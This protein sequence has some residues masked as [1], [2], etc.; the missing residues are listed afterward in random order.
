MT[1]LD[2]QID[3]IAYDGNGQ[4]VLLAE[5]R[6]RMGKSPEWAARFR[7]NLLEHG[8][9][10]NARFFLIATPERMYFWNRITKALAMNCR[11]SRSMRPRN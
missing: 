3:L 9:L 1:R 7:H 2:S 10:P 11:N 6:S 8:L 4:V 5:A